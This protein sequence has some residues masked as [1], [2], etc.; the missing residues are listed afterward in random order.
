[1]VITLC[2][3]ARFRKEIDEVQK[4]LALKGHLIFT[5]ENLQGIDITEEIEKMLDKVHRQK[6][7]LSDAIYVI[8]VDGYIGESTSNEIEYARIKGKKVI[9][10]E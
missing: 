1:M 5:I 9:Y 2:G 6:I 3:S 8:N 10:M 7:D 4:N